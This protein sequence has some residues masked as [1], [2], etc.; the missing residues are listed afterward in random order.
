MEEECIR[1]HN[2]WASDGRSR[3]RPIYHHLRKLVLKLETLIE[4]RETEMAFLAMGPLMNKDSCLNESQP[5]FEGLPRQERIP[6]QE[7]D[8]LSKLITYARIR[9][10]AIE[11]PM[12]FDTSPRN[13]WISLLHYLFDSGCEICAHRNYCPEWKATMFPRL[14]GLRLR[15]GLQ[16]GDIYSDLENCAVCLV[17]P[18]ICG[19]ID[20]DEWVAEMLTCAIP[21]FGRWSEARDT[22]NSRGDPDNLLKT[23]EWARPPTGEKIDVCA[24]V[25]E[26]LKEKVRLSYGLLKK[27]VDQDF[28]KEVMDAD[29]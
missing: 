19:P 18:Q 2:V 12:Y 15:S 10:S 3:G 13:V 17:P 26:A 24:T 23:A 20:P 28:D 21:G 11:N 8:R 7:V 27:F 25:V 4:N 22:W 5:L 9:L 16:I 14:A 6:V 1:Q 29:K